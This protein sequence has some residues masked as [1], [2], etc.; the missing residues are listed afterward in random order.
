M[1][2][3]QK[4]INGPESSHSYKL[5]SKEYL[6]ALENE[7]ARTERNNDEH[8]KIFIESG[9]LS[10]ARG[11]AYIEMGKTKLTVAVFD[12][13]EIPKNN[14]FREEGDLYCDFKF[15]PFSC[16][17]RKPLQP[18]ADEKSLA[19]ALKCALKPAVCRYTFPNFQVDVFVNVL[20]NDGSV[21]AAAICAAGVALSDAGI[22]M[23]DVITGSCVA[24][25]EEK[26][27]LDPTSTEEE[28][29][30]VMG[31]IHG[32]ITLAKLSTLD[33]VSEIFLFGYLPVH[34]IKKGMQFTWKSD[35]R[36]SFTN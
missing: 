20:E 31:T 4:R 29:C 21:L 14:K 32:T 5:Y 15:S 28:I 23:Y 27:Y 8:R 11:S 19:L 9:T 22:P 18:D 30:N 24:I 1:P 13:R 3:D 12:P 26:L 25:Q 36:N 16:V 10:N 7:L 2:Q 6:T 17:K 33:Q 34:T 35:R